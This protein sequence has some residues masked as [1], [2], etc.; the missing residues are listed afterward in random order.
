VTAV[1]R[2]AFGVDQALAGR[3]TTP[4]LMA[5]AVLLL[6]FAP[7]VLAARWRPLTAAVVVLAQLLLLG[8]TQWTALRPAPE[9]FLWKR[10]LAA[11][12]VSL[13]VHD[14]AAISE[15]YPSATRALQVG[16][17]VVRAG[18]AIF[19][20]EPLRDLQG[21]IGAIRRD[22]PAPSCMGAIDDG[23]SVPDEQRFV[24]I[25]GWLR[26]AD[27]GEARQVVAVSDPSGRI[28]GY[29]LSGLARPDVAAALGPQAL[30]AGFRGY[31]LREAMGS[32]LTLHHRTSPCALTGA[33][34]VP[35]FSAESQPLGAELVTVSPAA[36]TGAN[37]W[38]GQDWQKS[39]A[40]GVSVL[41]SFIRS[42]RD[43]GQVT[44]RLHPRDR[45]FF[46]SG[47]VNRR[48]RIRLDD[49]V[50]LEMP[51]CADWTLLT[52]EGLRDADGSGVVV[53]FSDEGTD[54]GEWS[55]IAIRAGP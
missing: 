55:A 6:L 20:T 47:P 35:L 44:L 42:D 29:V 23:V 27:Q 40:P 41:G 52:F 7:M 32:N 25:S 15:I 2:L 36:L 22:A 28:V 16:A 49:G 46:R 9:G 14:A 1:G 45:L 34:H 53:T 43:T 18:L 37:Q 17:P 19:G 30:H 26:A 39:Q 5:W 51:S 3:Y 31:V 21:S 11:L 4:T 33:T 24:L 12:A 10:E 8:P 38:L 13:G 48:Q 54:W 50:S